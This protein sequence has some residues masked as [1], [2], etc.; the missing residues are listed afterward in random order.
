MELSQNYTTRS[1]FSAYG[2]IAV[3]EGIGTRVNSAQSVLFNAADYNYIQSHYIYLDHSQT[4][5]GSFG[6]SYLVNETR[7]YAEVVTGSGL[8]T[9]IDSAPNGG[10]LPA[11]DS[12]NI[13]FTQGFQWAHLDNLSARFDVT[14]LF[15]QV[16][17]LR[18]GA[19][20]GVFAPQFGA[21]RAFFGGVTYSF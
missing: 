16:Y 12:A 14:N 5:T 18:D 10:S 3:E 15:D 6:I 20:V 21:R 13:G 11:Y 19:G 7:P 17:E 2:N 4:F 9:D 1:G 8:R